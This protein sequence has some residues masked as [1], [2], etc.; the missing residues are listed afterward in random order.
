MA[1]I[2]K[3]RHWP[4]WLIAILALAF[5]LLS[6]LGYLGIRSVKKPGGTIEAL[7]NEELM[8]ALGIQ[9]LKEELRVPQF[10][11]PDLKGNPTRLADFEGS[12]VLLN[13]WATWCPPCVEEMPSMERLHSEY[14]AQGL[15]EKICGGLLVLIGFLLLTNS[16]NLLVR[17]FYK[18]LPKGV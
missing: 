11:L 9:L 3:S 8:H 14:E 16:F 2:P 1:N 18:L 10:T 13:F 5:I 17:Y 15:V 6:V 7:S 4:Y 12:L